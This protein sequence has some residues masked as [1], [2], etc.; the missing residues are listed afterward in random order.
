MNWPAPLLADNIGPVIEAV[1]LL[2]VGVTAVVV[3]MLG[4]MK[5]MGPPPGGRPHLPA[6]Q[7]RPQGNIQNEIDE[8]LRR[9]QAGGGQRRPAQAR[10]APAGNRPQPPVKA[11]AVAEESDEPVGAEVV[12]HVEKYLDT[13]DFARRSQQLSTEAVQA[14]AALDEHMKQTFGHEVSRLARKPG[15]TAMSTGPQMT[16]EAAPQAAVIMPPLSLSTLV[17]DPDAIRQAIMVNEILRRPEERW[18]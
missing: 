4:G 5:Q 9:V 3:R 17:G 15:E 7:P 13:G 14:D 16:D 8:F 6:G 18:A 2:V 10:P 11:E 1:I 12:K